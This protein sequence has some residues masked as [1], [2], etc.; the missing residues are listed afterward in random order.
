VNILG[1]QRFRIIEELLQKHEV[2]FLDDTLVV[3]DVSLKWRIPLSVHDARKLHF[4][5]NFSIFHA[6]LM[7]RLLTLFSQRL[8]F[9]YDILVSATVV[10]P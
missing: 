2:T 9:W 3:F 1:A 4:S 10:I 7:L 6:R 8:V 5:L